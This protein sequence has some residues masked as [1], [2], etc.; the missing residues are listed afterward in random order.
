MS[1]E[2]DGQVGVEVDVKDLTRPKAKVDDLEDSHIIPR[3]IHKC[4]LAKKNGTPFTVAGTGRPLRQ[5]VH[6]YD[7][8]KMFIWQLREYNDVEP[9]IFSVGEDE[10]VS[11]RYVAEQIVAA[12]GFTGEV[13]F[14]TSKSDGQFRKPAPNEKL[15]RL[16]RETSKDKEEFKFTPFERGLKET[17]DWFVKNYDNARIGQVK[18]GQVGTA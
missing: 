17:V 14:D 12:V 4:C 3:L 15:L 10:D 6:S 16:V 13:R 18:R 1:F 2:L 9:I 5:F 7:L 11:I 8:A